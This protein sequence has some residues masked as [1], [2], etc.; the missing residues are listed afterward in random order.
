[1]PAIVMNSRQRQRLPQH[2]PLYRSHQPVLNPA[3]SR[4]PLPH[5]ISLPNST[6]KP[7]PKS[8]HPKGL[9]S[10]LVPIY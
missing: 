1:M 6:Q 9:T 5:L 7:F 4:L 2:R 3:R 8:P 10:L